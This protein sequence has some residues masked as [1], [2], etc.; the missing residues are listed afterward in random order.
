MY[1]IIWC[2]S[3]WQIKQC[4]I[5]FSLALYLKKKI[6]IVCMPTVLVVVGF[7]MAQRIPSVFQS[8]KCQSREPCKCHTLG[9]HW[10]HLA[11]WSLDTHWTSC[12]A[13]RLCL[14][15]YLCYFFNFLVFYQGP[16]GVL[17]PLSLSL[18]PLV[19]GFG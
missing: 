4:I 10:R 19:Y 18:C 12:S 8:N 15:F 7:H 5:P 17:R 2:I 13:G 9:Q 16:R 1:A 11:N 3:S 14:S 6:F